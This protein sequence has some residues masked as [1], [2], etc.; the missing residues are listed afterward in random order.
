MADK[1]F[2]QHAIKRPGA[3][4]RKAKASGESPMQF[5]RQHAHAPGKTGA[6]SRFALILAGLHH[7]K[8]KGR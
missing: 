3:L 4:T 2:I 5:A 6:Q 8:R 7:G 1:H